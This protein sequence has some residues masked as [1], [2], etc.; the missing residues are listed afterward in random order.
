MQPSSTAQRKRLP[1]H[2]A[3]STN[4]TKQVRDNSVSSSQTM[5]SS[6]LW[7]PDTN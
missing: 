6:L 1:R 7:L 3:S 4:G 2:D 5:Y